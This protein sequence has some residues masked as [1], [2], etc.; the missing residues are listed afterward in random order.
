MKTFVTLIAICISISTSAQTK[1]IFHKSHSGQ[2]S[3]FRTAV[4]KNLFGTGNSNVGLVE[5][6]VVRLDSVIYIDQ[7]KTILV[8]STLYYSSAQ[9][10]LA[11]EKNKKNWI[12]SRQT[13]KNSTLFN[14]PH[15][16]DSIKKTLIMEQNYELVNKTV[17]I[18]FD[19]KKPIN[20]KR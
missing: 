3:T 5:K 10:K 11:K 2:N 8:T 12:K 4:V 7:T 13:I 6:S 9:D 20:N 19:N 16:L 18:G 14:N 1:L 17:F 15:A